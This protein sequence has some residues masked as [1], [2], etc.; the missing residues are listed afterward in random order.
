M[1]IPI[2]DQI[3]NRIHLLG[4]EASA[5][6]IKTGFVTKTYKNADGTTSEY[7]VF[8]P[9]DYDGKKEYPIILFLHGAGETK[10]DKGGKTV[11]LLGPWDSKPEEGVYSYLSGLGKALLGKT[12]GENANVLGEEMI[13]E[14]IETWT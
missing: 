7:V 5:A 14:K 6:D 8:V 13:I 3:T 4:F 10:G 2:G 12:V 1:R 9:H 11:T